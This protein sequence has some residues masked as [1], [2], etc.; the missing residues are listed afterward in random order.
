MIDL[1][2]LI[3]TTINVAASVLLC[4][5]YFRSNLSRRL[6]QTF[7]VFTGIVAVSWI[8]LLVTELYPPWQV[9]DIRV[10]VF[11]GLNAVAFLYLGWK[12]IAGRGK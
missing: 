6:M 2:I 1:I 11:R 3:L 9:R 10:I 4:Y 7:F 8:F 12:L 5:L